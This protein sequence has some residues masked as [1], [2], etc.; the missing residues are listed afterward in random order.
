MIYVLKVVG[1]NGGAVSLNILNLFSN[2]TYLIFAGNLVLV[3]KHMCSRVRVHPPLGATF[4]SGRSHVLK[5][6]IHF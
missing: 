1:M 3:Y 4:A 6:V 2:G 5:S